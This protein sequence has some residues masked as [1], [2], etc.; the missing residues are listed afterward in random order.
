VVSVTEKAHVMRQVRTGKANV[1]EPLLMCRKRS[2]GTKTG[3]QL[4][5]REEPGGYLLTALVVSGMKVARARFRR[6]CGTR[7]RL[8]PMPLAGCWTGWRKGEAQAAE[9]VRARVP[10]RG[11]RADRLVVV[12]TPGNAGRAKGTDCP[13]SF[14]DQPAVPGGVG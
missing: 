8:A 10:M 11:R 14:D 3:V 12:M 5:P 7:E 13:G 4:L 6:Q 1:S 2:G 9:T